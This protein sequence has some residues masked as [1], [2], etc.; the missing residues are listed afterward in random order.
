[1]KGI[2][3]NQKTGKFKKNKRNSESIEEVHM[4]NKLFFLKKVFPVLKW[5]KYSQWLR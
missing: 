3:L 1:M 2:Y 4:K 5:I